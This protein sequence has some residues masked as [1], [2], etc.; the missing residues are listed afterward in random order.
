[1]HRNDEERA[2]RKRLQEFFRQAHA[3]DRPPSF[4]AV[5]ES[6]RPVRRGP[7]WQ[8]VAALAAVLLVA[9]AV[10]WLMPRLTGP[11]AAPLSE[12]EQLALASELS[13][14]RGPLDFLLETP[15]RE[16]LIGAP[17][18]ELDTLTIPLPAM[19]AAD[20]EEMQL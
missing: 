13:G 1:M 12:E 4:A 11:G 14:W 18:F 8:P 2:D 15:G 5:V 3:D 16:V 20:G 7:L 17:S 9:I 6:R 10:A 19:P